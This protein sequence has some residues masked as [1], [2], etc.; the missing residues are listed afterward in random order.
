M[1]FSIVFKD[2]IF[3]V[4]LTPS[5]FKMNTRGTKKWNYIDKE[6]IRNFIAILNNTGQIKLSIPL[7]ERTGF[8]LP[9]DMSVFRNISLLVKLLYP[10][11]VSIEEGKTILLKRINYTH[12]DFIERRNKIKENK[13]F[14]IENNKIKIL[15]KTQTTITID[16]REVKNFRTKI[17]YEFRR[18]LDKKDS[19]YYYIKKY[20]QPI[21]GITTTSLFG[22]SIQYDRL[23]DP[24]TI[25]ARWRYLGLTSGNATVI[26]FSPKTRKL[27]S[28]AI[29][30]LG[31][32]LKTFQ[33][34]P[35]STKITRIL[36]ELGLKREDVFP[37]KCLHKR[38]VYFCWL[39]NETD[40]FRKDLKTYTYINRPVEDIYAYWYKRWFERRY[41]KYKDKL[42]PKDYSLPKKEML[43][44]T[45]IEEAPITFEFED[46]IMFDFA[47]DDI[48]FNFE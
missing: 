19:I 27:M 26:H 44:G 33:S 9:N 47:D 17:D 37:E 39:I 20:E 15:D 32:T 12:E 42:K 14:H 30:Q 38:G 10:E 34:R 6:D 41:N 22:E 35:T 25:L 2:K 31:I 7:T 29:K 4:Q 23:W 40:I 46:E 21:Y 8:T 5:G 43:L 24:K 16:Y 18:N 11:N 48:V 28:K 3:D 36:S 45:F 1:G 13:L